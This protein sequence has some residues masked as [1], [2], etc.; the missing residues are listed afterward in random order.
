MMTLKA[1][2]TGHISRRV[3]SDIARRSSL[4]QQS[5]KRPITGTHTVASSSVDLSGPTKHREER[6]TQIG[7]HGAFD[8]GPTLIGPKMTIAQISARTNSCST[9]LSESA[10]PIRVPEE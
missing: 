3:V 6:P 4:A 9:E 8:V 7:S 1:G 2:N 10:N 5:K